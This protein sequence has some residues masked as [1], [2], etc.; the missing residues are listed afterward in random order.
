MLSARLSSSPSA[1]RSRSVCLHATHLWPVGLASTSTCAWVWRGPFVSS[2]VHLGTE[3]C[4]DSVHRN[5]PHRIAWRSDRADF[6]EECA[7]LTAVVSRPLI[8]C[9]APTDSAVLARPQSTDPL[10]FFPNLAAGPCSSAAAW[11]DLNKLRAP[12][13]K[14]HH[15][16]RFS[17]PSCDPLGVYKLPRPALTPYQN[18]RHR[19]IARREWW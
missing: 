4:S 10:R 13:N 11:P 12:A 19:E 5:K 16:L 1:S 8:P 18:L 14:L 17:R 15:Q 9:R 6:V 7:W 3:P 2:S